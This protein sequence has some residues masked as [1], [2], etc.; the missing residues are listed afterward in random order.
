MLLSVQGRGGAAGRASS[1]SSAGRMRGLMHEATLAA[2]RPGRE[3]CRPHA[4]LV[5][6]LCWPRL[7]CA[8][9]MALAGFVKTAGCAPFFCP[10]GLAAR[11]AV[12]GHKGSL[13]VEKVAGRT[14]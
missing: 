2:C 10:C 3:L 12:A 13:C 8:T 9:R 4:S 14:W 1:S 7:P 11:A 6:G 5:R